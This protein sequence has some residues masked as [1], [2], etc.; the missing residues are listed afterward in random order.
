MYVTLRNDFHGTTARVSLPGGKG[1]VSANA[2]ARALKKLCGNPE[3]TC[4]QLRGKQTASVEL[5]HDA[6]TG[7]L[8]LRVNE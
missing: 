4:G 7:R 1:D 5:R 8:Y 6:Y 3:C 2:T